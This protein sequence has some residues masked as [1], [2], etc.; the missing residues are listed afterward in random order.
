MSYQKNKPLNLSGTMKIPMMS[1]KMIMMT[2]IM[3]ST[4]KSMTKIMMKNLT[5]HTMKSMTNH[6]TKSMR[7][8][9]TKRSMIKK[10]NLI[11]RNLIERNNKLLKIR[12]LKTV[13][14]SMKTTTTKLPRKIY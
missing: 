7:N 6:T 11:A 14:V 1:I 12:F 4:R 8:I 13:Y 3:K 10:I 9:T 2:S 5:K